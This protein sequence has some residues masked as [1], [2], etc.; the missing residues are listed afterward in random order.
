MLRVAYLSVSYSS[1]LV[2]GRWAQS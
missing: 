1:Q 2:A